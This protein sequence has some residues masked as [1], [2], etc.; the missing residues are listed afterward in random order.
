DPVRMV[1]MGE[2]SKE[3]CGG[4]HLNNTSEVEA[5]EIVGEEAVSAGTRRV[6]A[7]TGTRAREN[8]SQTR[9]A[10]A[11]AAE[12]LGVAPLAVPEAVRALAQ[13][14]RDARRVLTSGGKPAPEQPLAKPSKMASEQPDYSD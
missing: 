13:S 10:L 5:F 11:S 9:Q 2:F 3:L 1:S 14:V 8:A 4:T 6:V 7:L 12:R